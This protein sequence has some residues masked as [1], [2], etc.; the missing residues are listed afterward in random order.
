M[1]LAGRGSPG[2]ASPIGTR[3]RHGPSGTDWHIK[4]RSPLRR[5]RSDSPV[6]SGQRLAAC[7][8]TSRA[9]QVP[10]PPLAHS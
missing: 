2:A 6:A 10:Q 1:S 7:P 3:S 5:S 8:A 4:M 9:R